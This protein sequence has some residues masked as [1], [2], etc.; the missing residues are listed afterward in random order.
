MRQ[1]LPKNINRNQ[2]KKDLLYFPCLKRMAN[3]TI[4]RT[5]KTAN[6]NEMN[7]TK[8]DWSLNSL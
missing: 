4:Q 1:Y 5:D 7:E 2:I 3:K 6:I 8:P